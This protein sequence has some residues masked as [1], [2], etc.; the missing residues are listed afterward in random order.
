MNEELKSKLAKIYALVNQGATEGERAAAKTA[1]DRL[2]VKYSLDGVDLESIDKSDYFFGY[3]S[4]LEK[5]LLLQIAK[6][7][8]GRDVEIYIRSWEK[9]LR[10]SLKY[11]DYMNVIC[12]YEYFRRHMKEQ[13]NV[14]CL[15]EVNRCR[16]AKT[17]L[18]R[19]KELQAIFIHQYLMKSDLLLTP[20]IKEEEET[21]VQ[22]VKPTDVAKQGR[23]PMRAYKAN[24]KDYWLVAGVEGGS[25]MKQVQ[26]AH[27]LPEA[28]ASAGQQLSLF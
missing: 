8:V 5:A 19:R 17:K 25:Y 14:L 11:V 16:K 4:D 15:P 6:K 24:A 18:K 2:I 26:T 21:E 22:P 7:L 3:S 27:Q 9:N 10:I 12:A 1:L 13:W 23:K 20:E 28:K